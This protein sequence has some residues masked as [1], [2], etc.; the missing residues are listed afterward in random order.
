MQDLESEAN[1]PEKDRGELAF[2][3]SCALGVAGGIVGGF[4]AEKSGYG[5]AILASTPAADALFL[6]LFTNSVDKDDRKQQRIVN[7][8]V[9]F[10]VGT[11]CA[12]VGYGLAYMVKLYGA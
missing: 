5:Y 11:L 12:G 8:V 10:G 3:V 1:K 6:S 2:L 4:V 9:G 7:V